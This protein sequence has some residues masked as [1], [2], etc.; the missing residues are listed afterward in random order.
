MNKIEKVASDIRRFNRFYLPF[1]H[2]LTQ[3]YLNSDYSMAEVRILYEIYEQGKIRATD[4]VS[5]LHVDKG[6]LSRILRRFEDRA[7][8]Q[9]KASGTDLRRSVI[10]LTE[11]GTC[12]AESLIAESNR[13]IAEELTSLSEN[14]LDRLTDLM[15]EIIEILEGK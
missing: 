1:F 15:S 6:Y 7:I 8:I 10:S 4:I 14:D 3:K 12:L 13:Q 11:T 9:K 2:L 5:R